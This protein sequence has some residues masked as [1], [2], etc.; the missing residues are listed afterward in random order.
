MALE[1]SVISQ[2]L[3]RPRNFE[4]ALSIEEA[5]RRAGAVPATF[6]VVDGVVRVGLDRSLL[7][8][9][10]YG[11]DIE[12]AGARDLSRAIATR[13]TMATTVGSSLIIAA[14]AG[15]SVLATGGIGGVHRG[16]NETGDVSNDLYVLSRTR[17]ITVCSGVKSVLDLPKTMELLE[18]LGVPLLGFQTGTLPDFYGIDSGLEVPRVD[19]TSIVAAMFTAQEELA[20]RSGIIVVNPPPSANAFDRAELDNLVASALADAKRDDVSGKEVTPYLLSHIARAT[21]GRS[22]DLNIEL[23]VSNASLAARIAVSLM[24]PT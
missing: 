6:A 10:A 14:R 21:G 22:V 5:V 13:A 2:G 1:S 16:A 19:D 12:K 3:P 24:P 17:S 18:S 7:E 23:L 15:I 8:R 4:A 20:V 9:M 11:D